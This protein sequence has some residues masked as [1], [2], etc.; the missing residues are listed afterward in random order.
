MKKIYFVIGRYLSM[1]ALLCSTLLVPTSCIDDQYDLEKDL[2][3]EMSLLGSFS[4]PIGSTS[5][6]LLKDMIDTTDIDMLEVDEDG[7][8]KISMKDNISVGIDSIA[9]SSDVSIDKISQDIDPIVTDFEKPE[10]PSFSLD[11]DPQSTSVGTG[12]ISKV[13]LDG[14]GF[15][16]NNNFTISISGASGIPTYG[17]YPVPSMGI[18]VGIDESVIPFSF[19]G[20][21]SCPEQ[22]E[23][24]NYVILGSEATV[25]FDVTSLYNLFTPETFSLTIPYIELTFPEGFVIDGVNEKVRKESADLTCVNGKVSF[26]F[27]I[28]KY[29]KEVERLATGY[30][31]A[32]GGDIVFDMAD[33]I[34]VSGTTSGS[35]ISSTS[36]NI[37]VAS[38]ILVTDMSLAVGGIN[39]E[40]ETVD[41]LG[42]ETYIEISD[43][44]KSITTITL[45][46]TSNAIEIEISG[47]TVP[48]G[49]EAT[50]NDIEIQFPA[51]KFKLTESQSITLENNYYSL[52]IPI[53]S[54]VGGSGI[55][56]TI[57]IEEIYFSAE[58]FSTTDENG[59]T[60][61]DYI[62]MVFDPEIKMAGTTI[63][64]A[65]DMLFS[66][67]NDFVDEE[68]Q[69]L[70]TAVSASDLKVKSADIVVNDYLAELDPITQVISETVEVPEELER[71]DSM[72]FA[73]P[74][75]ININIDIELEGTESDISFQNYTIE[76][77]EFI[78]FADGVAVDEDNKLVLNDVFEKTTTGRSYSAEFEIVA[79][80]LSSYTDLI[81]GSGDNKT[82]ALNDTVKLTGNIMM[83]SGEV[84]SEELSSSITA[85]VDFSIDAMKIA[86]VYGIVNPDI[87]AEQTGISL[88]DLADVIEGDF[89]AVLTD[90]TVSISIVNTLSVPIKLE[91]LTLQPTKNGVDLDSVYINNSIYIEAAP[92]GDSTTTKVYISANDAPSVQE[93]DVQYIKMENFKNL[94]ANLPDSIII[95]FKAAAISDLSEL[96]GANHMIDLYQSYEFRIDYDINI[97]LTFDE[98][99]LEYTATMSDIGSDLGDITDMV[100]SIELTLEIDNT[101]PISLGVSK[102]VAVDEDGNE[103][104]ELPA[105]IDE[106]G[107]VIKANDTSEITVT[108]ADNEAGDHKVVRVHRTG[109]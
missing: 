5:Q 67:F 69:T 13:N 36:L 58:D 2:D 1:L 52:A 28:T 77:P 107:A 50:G 32:I 102:V 84:D 76:F 33:Q 65:G 6:I 26:S 16:L 92:E 64:M 22:V 8:Y 44:V 23:K 81:T 57:N 78:R 17:G 14:A 48:T 79:I 96:A 63:T 15:S 62:Y 105:F 66:N 90:P 72:L 95:D 21:I 60:K 101:M 104:T 51:S 53:S 99:S 108:I 86:K 35:S 47:I 37:N 20:N 31:E 83:A 93:P 39:T 49:L 3:M 75:N 87:P 40:V 80:D 46:N 89:S 54:I 19:G 71:I 70:T 85:N 82:L 4:L 7:L 55:N 43:L 10:I 109:D 25:E 74:V 9:G 103:L 27:I 68:D 59:E 98:L 73:T 29:D 45:D 100:S 18:D 94:L 34:T 42:S 61:E 88:E 91:S 56:E 11:I 12:S 38:D 24:V 97:P 41:N 30:L 106:D